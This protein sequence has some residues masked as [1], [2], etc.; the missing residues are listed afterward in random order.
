MNAAERIFGR[1]KAIIGMCHARALPGRPGH[2]V[3]GGLDAIFD[4]LAPDLEALQRG[5][6][7]GI[8]FCN[9]G[10]L[11]YQ[12]RVGPEIVAAMAAVVGRLRSELSLPFG[13]DLVWDPIASLSVARATGASFVRGVFTGVYD[14]DMGLMSPVLGDLYGFRASIGANDVAVF[15]NITPEFGQPISGR[16]VEERAI[17]AVYN[18]VDGLIVSGLHTGLLP[19][20]DVLKRVKAAVPDALVIASSGLSADNVEAIL[21]VADAGIVGTSL[22]VDGNTWNSVDPERVRRFIEVVDRCRAQVV[23]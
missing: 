4:A 3:R 23:A 21:A 2:D 15:T 10:D 8:L 7:D 16:P 6:V 14:T 11:P 22:K 18:G 1:T 9:E 19:D 5:G 20:L 17:G 12:L 13:V